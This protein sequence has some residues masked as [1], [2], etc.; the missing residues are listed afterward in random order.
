MKQDEEDINVVMKKI[1]AIDT[2]VRLKSFGKTKPSVKAP[3]KAIKC[4]KMCK[5]YLC[6]QC[7]SPKEKDEDT[8]RRI[9]QKIQSAI[10]QIEESKQ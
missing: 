2:K 8:H 3:A 1:N 5:L 7:K 9:T 4:K 6:D 10:V